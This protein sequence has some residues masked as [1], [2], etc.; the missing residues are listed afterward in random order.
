MR[1]RKNDQEAREAAKGG[2]ESSLALDLILVGGRC[3]DPRIPRE[4][5]AAAVLAVVCY[6]LQ[7]SHSVFAVDEHGQPAGMGA[8]GTHGGGC[9][10][11]PVGGDRNQRAISR[12]HDGASVG[13][14][15]PRLD[16]NLDLR[17]VGVRIPGPGAY[18]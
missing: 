15:E 1:T 14:T 6:V 5:S 10:G 2:K 7:V 11:D 13:A 16:V 9:A 17:C 3:S 18:P 4:S 12:C 8:G